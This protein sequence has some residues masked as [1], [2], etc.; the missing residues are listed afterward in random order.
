MK[1]NQHEMSWLTV[2]KHAADEIEKRRGQLERRGLSETDTEFERGAID[3]LRGVLA[4]AETD[5][6][7]I[8]TTPIDY[9]RI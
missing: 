4:L 5:T 7:R 3:A 6:D 2:A 1:I 9:M 8:P